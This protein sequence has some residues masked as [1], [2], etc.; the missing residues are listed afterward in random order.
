MHTTLLC[1]A[2]E[3]EGW[4]IVVYTSMATVGLWEE[5]WAGVD[6]LPDSVYESAGGNGHSRTNT[7]WYIAT[8][9]KPDYTWA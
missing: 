7:L 3:D 1:Q 4:S 9:P 2:C 5:A 8:R 6:E